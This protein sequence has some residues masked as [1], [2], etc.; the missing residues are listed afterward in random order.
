MLAVNAPLRDA[1]HAGPRSNV[2]KKLME[3]A[4]RDNRNAQ[5]EACRALSTL[6]QSESAQKLLIEAVLE[7]KA[8]VRLCNS[9]DAEIKA[10]AITV[11]GYFATES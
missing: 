6:A 8:V 11:V 2:V 7:R 4:G 5:C 10:L 9:P 1:I 3:L